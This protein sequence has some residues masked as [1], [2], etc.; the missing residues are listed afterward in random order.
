MASRVRTRISFG[1]FANLKNNMQQQIGL[2]TLITSIK[3]IIS[4]FNNNFTYIVNSFNAL[5]QFKY[6]MDYLVTLDKEKQEKEN[7]T[8][9]IDIEELLEKLKVIKTRLENL[10]KVF[11]D[12]SY[13]VKVLVPARI[14]FYIKD[15][16][17]Q[18]VNGTYNYNGN[19]L[20]WN[21][22]QYGKKLTFIRNI[23]NSKLLYEIGYETMCGV[24][25][26]VGGSMSAP[27]FKPGYMLVN[28]INTG[29]R[30]NLGN[31]KFY[32]NDIKVIK[33]SITDI[34]LGTL[35]L[36]QGYD[37][38]SNK[39]GINENGYMIVAM[40]LYG[41]E[42]FEGCRELKNGETIKL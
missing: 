39:L 34:E 3:N 12:G 4:T 22:D 21:I 7:I 29:I 25:S 8:E 38:G 20:T 32:S 18:P 9:N 30:Y 14:E 28:L 26:Y 13:K 10:E 5:M 17:I 37:P 35:K 19:Y 6:K 36:Y 24:S 23:N 31:Y 11:R 15:Y 41:D 40:R 2:N 42:N 1:A 33:D 16:R 27:G